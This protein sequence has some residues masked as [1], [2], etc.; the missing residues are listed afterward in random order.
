MSA[1]RGLAYAQQACASCHAVQAGQDVSPNSGAPAFTVIA[2]TPGMTPTALNA[3]LHSAHASMPNLIVEPND[4]A[5]VAAYLETLR[6]SGS[7]G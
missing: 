7:A 4:R 2:N 1:T 5:D 3:W 6:R